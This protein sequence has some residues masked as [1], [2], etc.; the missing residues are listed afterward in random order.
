MN[1]AD[2]PDQQIESMSIEPTES[3]V[4][5]EPI[6][7]VVTPAP[8]EGSE[9]S[10][11]DWQTVDFPG[12]MSVDALPH[13]AVEGW[14]LEGESPI[15]RRGN[16]VASGVIHYSSAEINP[17][18]T[19]IGT[20]PLESTKG[21]ATLPLQQQATLRDRLTQA[22]TAL[23]HLS[24]EEL[25][26][27][28]RS[29]AVGNLL[30]STVSS[31]QEQPLDS[32]QE[33]LQQLLQE[34]ER[35]HQT[36]QRQQILVETLTEQLSSSQERIAQ[37]ERDCALTQQRHN[38]QVQQVLQAENTCRDLRLR[39]HRQQ[40]QT[41][42]FKAALEKSLEM[43]AVYGHPAITDIAPAGHAT[44][45]DASA[46]LPKNSPVKPWSLAKTLQDTTD[47][48]DRPDRLFK[49][50]NTDASAPG[51]D[52]AEAKLTTPFSGQSEHESI[53]ASSDLRSPLD[54]EDPQ[55]VNHL[56]QLI[57]PIAKTQPLDLPTALLQPA[58]HFD[59][60]PF[61]EA[62]LEAA[63][64]IDAD[65]L[66]PLEA[67]G[68]MLFGLPDR[69][70]EQQQPDVSSFS[71]ST[72]ANTSLSPLP[73]S[74]ATDP[75]WDNLATLIDLPL[76]TDLPLRTEDSDPVTTNVDRP[77]ESVDSAQM[78][79]ASGSTNL[80]PID[81]QP[82]PSVPTSTTAI[83]PIFA[84]DASPLED[85]ADTAASQTAWTWRDRLVNAGK[86][87]RSSDTETVAQ[88]DTNV[89]LD[90][91]DQADQVVMPQPAQT[92]SRSTVASPSF[93]V[94]PSPIVYPLRPAKKLASL[95]AVDLPMFPKR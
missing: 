27:R 91:A 26:A 52:G 9:G 89:T 51:Q 84:T 7:S 21:M 13:E 6:P 41:L 3:T 33:R 54:S 62:S 47:A 48:A 59:L 83:P 43:P 16:A 78:S 90:V 77:L 94:L 79:L 5:S 49:L 31:S 66:P 17:A 86:I 24:D 92:V 1:E 44:V 45:P 70:L 55:F 25:A 65:S 38:E 34:L 36:A 15:E 28:H 11:Q 80:V 30:E 29:Q 46:L 67:P 57:F 10:T 19:Y 64:C 39:L 58:P 69:P 81:K 82:S 63:E 42:Q 68:S 76:Q 73:D 20:S 37:L 35:S 85:A 2:S 14:H 93:A 22:E 32:A 87:A 88:A 56:M 40:Q 74:S 23:E 18:A 72:I 8:I 12:A 4:V 53:A 71:L 61:S 60:D 95:A 50:L 75:L